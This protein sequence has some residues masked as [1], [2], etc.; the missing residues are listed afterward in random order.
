MSN[1]LGFVW[2][3]ISKVHEEESILILLHSGIHCACHLEAPSTNSTHNRSTCFYEAIR[4]LCPPLPSVLSCFYNLRSIEN[5]RVVSRCDIFGPS[6]ALE[7]NDMEFSPS[8]DMH[9]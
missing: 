5:A 3:I 1:F 9:I 6:A 4:E 2:K 8:Y 7:P